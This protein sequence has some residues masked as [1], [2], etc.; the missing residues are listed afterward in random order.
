MEK[1][2]IE[3]KEYTRYNEQFVYYTL[4]GLGLLVLEIFLANTRFRKIP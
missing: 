3:V 4:A 1:T 2:K